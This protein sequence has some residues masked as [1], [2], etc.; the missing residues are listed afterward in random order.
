MYSISDIV[1]GNGALMGWV[2]QRVSLT[3]IVAHAI[4]LNPSYDE[5]I[6]GWAYAKE[7]S[8]DRNCFAI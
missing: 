1:G 6:V 3:A 5:V 4:Q 8:P 7:T 2:Y